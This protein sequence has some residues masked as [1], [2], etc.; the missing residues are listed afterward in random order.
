MKKKFLVF[1]LML[2]L[3][4]FWNVGRAKGAFFWYYCYSYDSLTIS[5]SC[6]FYNIDGYYPYD[7]EMVSYTCDYKTVKRDLD[8]KCN[9]VNQLPKCFKGTDKEFCESARFNDLTAIEEA[10]LDK[11]AKEQI[12]QY[13]GNFCFCHTDIDKLSNTKRQYSSTPCFKPAVGKTCSSPEGSSYDIC[14]PFEAEETCNTHRDLLKNKADE[15]IASIGKANT[16]GNFIPGCGISDKEVIS[17][18]CRDVSIFVSILLNGANYLFGIVGALALLVVVLA[19][20]QLIISQGNPEKTKKAFDM[21]TAA[22]IGLLIVFGAYMLVRFFGT[23][24][25]L[26]QNLNL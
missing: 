3:S 18:E 20:I 10:K 5:P 17:P 2:L 22:G 6:L 4:F 7:V 21:L 16:V 23:T 19:G 1:G 26:D 25:G 8:H 12:N 15:T 11:V 13:L 9:S 24:M 14:E